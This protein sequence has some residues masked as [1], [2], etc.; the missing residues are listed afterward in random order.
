[1]A[2]SSGARKVDY[3]LR[4]GKHRKHGD[5][6]PP[7]LVPALSRRQSP[8]RRGT[9]EFRLWSEAS[10]RRRA[11]NP[12]SYPSTMTDGCRVYG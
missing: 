7:R 2:K 6:R 8:P 9:T 3:C 1:M 12:N 5:G 10:V 4:H 11:H